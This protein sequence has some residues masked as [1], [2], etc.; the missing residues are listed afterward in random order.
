[1]TPRVSAAS[2]PTTTRVKVEDLTPM[3]RESLSAQGQIGPD[4]FLD[5]EKPA[6]P[7]MVDPRADS[8]KAAIAALGSVVGKVA[9]ALPASVDVGPDVEQYVKEIAEL[10]AKLQ[11]RNTCPR[12]GLGIHE[13]CETKASAADIEEFLKCVLSATH[14]R[15]D[16]TLFGGKLRIKMTTRDGRTDDII[17]RVITDKLRLRELVSETEIYALMRHLTMAAALQEYVTTE[18]TKEYPALSTESLAAFEKEATARMDAIPAPIQSFLRPVLAEFNTLVDFMTERA[19]DA[20]FWQ[21][22][23]A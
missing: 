4:G 3:E 14:F 23:P 21:G 9:A 7:E 13:S 12:C 18:T 19:R 22:T 1:M 5:M 16:Y 20:S 17:R 10:Q 6:P 15:K 8:R 2:L 11:T